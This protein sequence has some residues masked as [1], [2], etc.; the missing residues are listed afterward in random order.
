MEESEQTPKLFLHFHMHTMHVWS[1]TYTPYT[2]HTY[3]E[4]RTKKIDRKNKYEKINQQKETK[5][6]IKSHH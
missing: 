3:T 2:S 4:G 6:I 1:H 5:M